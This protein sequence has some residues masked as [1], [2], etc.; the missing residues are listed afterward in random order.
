MTKFP[1]F[2]QF[3]VDVWRQ[4]TAASSLEECV[5]RVA[6]QLALLVPADALVVWRLSRDEALLESVA[7]SAVRAG[8]RP[9][10]VL[11]RPEP[12]DLD[13]L[14]RIQRDGVPLLTSR[15]GATAAQR[16][17]APDGEWRSLLLAPMGDGDGPMG[18]VSLFSRRSNVLFPHHVSLL[19]DLSAPLATA[20]RLEEERESEHRLR[21]ALEA[22]RRALLQRLDRDDVSDSIVGAESGLRETM[23]RV[24][25]VAPTDAPVLLLGETGSG[26]EV[27][28]RAIHSRSR[29]AR[30]PIV[31]VNCGAIP[32]GL[33]DSE[34]FGHE[35]G[36]FT[37]AITNRKGWFERADGGTLFLDE[38]GELPLDAQVRLLRI[39]QDGVFERVGGQRANR[40]DVRIIAATHR[41][42]REMVAQGTF[43]EDLWYRLSV[44]PIDIPPLRA[45][46]EDIPALGAHF[47]ARAGTRLGG[48]ALALSPNDIELLLTYAWPGN[49]RELAAV[50]ERA[51]ILGDG[52]HLRLAAA[53]G[54]TPVASPNGASDDVLDTAAILPLEQA[55]ARHIERALRATGGRI[56]GSGGAATLL[57]I[58]PHTLRAR[59]RKM[60]IDWARFR[61]D[62]GDLGTDV[63]RDRAT[64]R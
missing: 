30:G 3:V 64:T 61:D 9:A 41:N 19:S 62:A 12:R 45:R 35:K 55:M 48:N 32:L 26:K 20:V 51:V 42:L 36:S 57:Q 25:Q 17:F 53:L 16:R 13:E 18:F 54:P 27:I 43:R 52:R 44:F 38:V 1:E 34:L 4:A 23:L 10:P 6:E 21:E 29:R 50:I 28:A 11:W 47:A 7:A 31:R 33:I 15:E 22:D 59:M 39:L 49:V 5:D 46:P 14:R 37:G 56:E 40:V 2:Y 8:P 60:R 63:A 58:N 24:E